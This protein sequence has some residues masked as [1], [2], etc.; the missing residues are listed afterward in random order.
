MTGFFVRRKH[1]LEQ[2]AF[3][4]AVKACGEPPVQVEHLERHRREGI[5][6]WSG[7]TKLRADFDGS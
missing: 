6:G 5:A 3:A 1:L 4:A 2:V 7:T